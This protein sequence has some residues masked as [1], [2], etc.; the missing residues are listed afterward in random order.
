MSPESPKFTP[1]PN[2]IEE[3][4]CEVLGNCQEAGIISK[5]IEYE[6]MESE[7]D[8]SSI[9]YQLNKSVCQNEQAKKARKS[10]REE[11]KGN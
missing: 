3:E 10:A 5:E 2:C 11:I 7:F 6:R 4:F 9:K 8:S 1:G